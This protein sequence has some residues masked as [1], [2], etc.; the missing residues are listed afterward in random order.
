MTGFEPGDEVQLTVDYAETQMGTIG[1][2]TGVSSAYPDPVYSVEIT[3][4]PTG[5]AVTYRTIRVPYEKL[6]RA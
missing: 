4:K 2:V 3:E 6:E 5:R 1:T